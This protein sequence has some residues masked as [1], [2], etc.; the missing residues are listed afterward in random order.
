MVFSSAIFL[1]IF[2]PVVFVLY[3]IIPGIKAK[4]VLLLI[5]SIIFFAFGQLQYLPIIIFSIICNYVFGR[6]IASAKK[7]KATDKILVAIAV[8]VNLGVLAVFKYTD[9]IIENINSL[10][11]TSIPLPEI[12]LPIGISFFTFQGLSYV[13]DVSRDKSMVAKNFIKLALYI[14]LFPQLIAGPIIK[15]HDV[16]LQIDDRKCNPKL[17]S[18]GIRRFVSGLA[19]KLLIAN[20]VGVVVDK[21]FSLSPNA[22]DIRT[23]W[24]AAIF[25][26]LQIYFDF[27]GYSDMAIGLGK[28]FGFDFLE[29]FNYPYVSSSMK[30]F[31]RRWHISLSSWF[32]DYL[33]IPLGGNRK[34]KGRTMFNKLV[35][36]FCTGLWHGASW[37]FVLWGLWNGLFIILEDLIPA[38][39]KLPK[40]IGRIFT[41][42]VTVIGFVAFRASNMTEAFTVMG[43]MFTGFTFTPES[44]AIMRTILIPMIFAVIAIIASQPIL[45]KVKSLITSKGEGAIKTFEILSLVGTFA[46]YL[47]CILNLSATSF[48]PFIYFQF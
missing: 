28:M 4:N 39:K 24:I 37:N 8:V 26:A 36:F 5:A 40:A 18:A 2:L 44:D 43:K 25:Y 13:I 38:L 42:L 10:A 21:I 15:Y 27:S 14:S 9:F 22:I 16:S 7:G 17:T 20:S 1:F 46:I 3:R 23:A 31:W 30:E 33:Y 45:P 47:L 48:N 11:G 41:L 19:K 32:R 34:G 12:V 6:L 35:V 29:N